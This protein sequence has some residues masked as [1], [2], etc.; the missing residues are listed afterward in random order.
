MPEGNHGTW[1]VPFRGRHYSGPVTQNLL[2][3]SG[4]VYVMDNHRAAMW[5]WLRHIPPAA[6]HSLFHIDRHTDTLQSRLESDR[7]HYPANW[8]DLAIEDYLAL[9]FPPPENTLPLIRWDT[10]LAIY[11]DVFGGQIDGC[12]F[13]THDCGDKPNLNAAMEVPVWD[14]PDNI[15][16]WIERHDTPWIMN[17]DIDYFFAPLDHTSG[18]IQMISDDYISRCMDVVREKI[19]DGTIAVTTICLTPD[20]GYTGGWAQ[21]E[22]IMHLILDRL[23]IGFK[24]PV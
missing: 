8:F 21:S 17:I 22:R 4:N 14:V 1:H 24:L 7:Q 20:P 11:L 12:I 16:Y 18:A 10:Y 9:T 23:G 19:A 3:Q 15:D 5:C 2:W 13:A 6:K